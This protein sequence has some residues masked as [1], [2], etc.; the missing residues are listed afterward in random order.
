MIF[1]IFSFLFFNYDLI[2]NENTRSPGTT[3]YLSKSGNDIALNW[4]GDGV[5]YDCA[6][7]RDAEFHQGVQTLFID[8]NNT[9]YTYK[10][11]LINGEEILFFDVTDEVEQ[12]R[13]T[14]WNGGIM[15]PPPPFIDTSALKTNINSLYIGS[16]G[17]IK[18]SNFS[19]IPGDNKV[20]FEDGVCTWA[21]SSTGD[22]I[23]F[24]VPAGAS[25]GEIRVEVKGQVSEPAG[26][27]VNL[28]DTSLGW[29][30]RTMG[31]SKQS[32]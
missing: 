9:T 20:C 5:L 4:T 30:I 24:K 22:Q 8:L 3:L 32:G 23:T 11:G 27:T 13:G 29:L 25:S 14:N 26:A 12:N 21:M 6:I 28:E 16:E 7:S 31:Y 19:S 15:P 18:G 17:V 2:S 1:L 10:N